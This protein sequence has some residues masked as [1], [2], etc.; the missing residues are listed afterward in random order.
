MV[1]QKVVAQPEKGTPSSFQI[2]GPF[3]SRSEPRQDQRS[4]CDNPGSLDSTTSVQAVGK[5]G[6]RPLVSRLRVVR[7]DV[8]RRRGAGMAESSR[9]RADIDAVEQH[10]RRS[11]VAQIVQPDLRD[12]QMSGQT[13]ERERRVVRPPRRRP[14]RRVAEDKAISLDPALGVRK[15]PELSQGTG[16]RV[17]RRSAWVLVGRCMG[18][19][20]VCATWPAM[21]SV[22]RW[23]S[24]CFHCS[25]QSSPRLAPVTAASRKKIGR[26]R[27]TAFAAAMRRTTSS[28]L[29]R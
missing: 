20:A 8:Q 26:L 6:R 25:A 3:R 21:C 23:K 29:G 11:E 1:V 24:T 16:S 14:A 5:S 27:L 19:A 28:A 10:G 9:C 15:L 7:V 22:W 18:P 12:A 13:S 4:C 2:G 17:R